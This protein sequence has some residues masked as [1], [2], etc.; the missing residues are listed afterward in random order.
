MYKRQPSGLIST[1]Y[2]FRPGLMAYA[3]ASRGEK[4]GGVNATVPSTLGTDS[5]KVK[6]EIATSFE[7]GLK[8]QWFEHRLQVNADLFDSHIQDYQAT[9]ITTP[10][11]GGSSL[12]LLTNVGMVRTRGAELE[13]AAAPVNG[14]TLNGNVSYNDAIYLSYPNG[15]CAAEDVGQT[16]C[17][18]SGRPVAGAP[19][20]IINLNGEYHRD[21][22][23]DLQGF[24]GGEYSWRSTYYGYLDDSV[25]TKTGDFGLLNAHLGLRLHAAKWEASLWAKNL[26]NVRYVA[27]DLNDGSLLPGVYVPFYGD[28]RTYGFTVRA[29]F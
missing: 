7:I 10:P 20:W 5:L 21:L 19:R 26:T 23:N 18:L 4:A 1:D 3:L 9:Y 17:N 28:P 12:Q 16:S 11:G 24:I 15:P 6:P 8:S 25:Y 13:I 2:T 29:A 14:L 22:A 27:S